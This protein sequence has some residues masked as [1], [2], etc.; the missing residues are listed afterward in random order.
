M[1][2]E[3]GVDEAWPDHAE[4]VIIYRVTGTLSFELNG[5]LV[6]SEDADPETRWQANEW[7]NVAWSQDIEHSEVYCVSCHEVLPTIT[8]RVPEPAEVRFRAL[9]A[10]YG[11]EPADDPADLWHDESCPIALVERNLRGGSPRWFITLHPDAQ[12]AVDS[13]RDQEYPDDWDIERIV[14]CRD[15]TEYGVETQAVIIPKTV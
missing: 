3:M 2:Y 5:V 1:L 14:D 6:D 15:G 12:R 4:H 10:E 11:L 7:D 13:H 8:G 9:C